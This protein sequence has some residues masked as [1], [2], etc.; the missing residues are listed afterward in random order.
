MDQILNFL[1]QGEFAERLVE[2]IL[3]SEAVEELAC[4]L[5]IANI[6]GHFDQFDS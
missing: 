6:I 4:F 3:Q 2:L 1:R 5:K